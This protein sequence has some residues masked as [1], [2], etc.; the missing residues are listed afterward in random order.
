MLLW[1]GILNINISNIVF[2]YKNIDQVVIVWFIW[3]LREHFLVCHLFFLVWRFWHK[4]WLLLLDGWTLATHHWKSFVT[5]NLC[6]W[7][8]LF[9]WFFPNVLKPLLL[10][11]KWTLRWFMSRFVFFW[12]F[13]LFRVGCKFL[14]VLGGFC[15]KWSCIH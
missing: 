11:T 12:N 1:W 3:T 15:R 8:L 4:Q 9:K 14:Q 6:G 5:A 2:I 13:W 7:L 10:F